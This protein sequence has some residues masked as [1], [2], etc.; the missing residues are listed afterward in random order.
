MPNPVR[1]AVRASRKYKKPIINQDQEEVKP[2][3]RLLRQGDSSYTLA[4]LDQEL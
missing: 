3:A 2:A 1:S 4:S